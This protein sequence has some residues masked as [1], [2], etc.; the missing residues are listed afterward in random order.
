MNQCYMHMHFSIS[1]V[2]ECDT[3]NGG[4]K[5]TCTNL[6]GSFDCSCSEGYI[7]ADDDLNCV[8]KFL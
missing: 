7:L 6:E 5:Q 3:N 8:G 2:N 4:C 1:D